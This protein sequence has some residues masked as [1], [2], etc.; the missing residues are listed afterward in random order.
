MNTV[1]R[2]AVAKRGLESRAQPRSLHEHGSTRH[3]ERQSSHMANETPQS[4][5][6]HR[7][8]PL[9]VLALVDYDNVKPQNEL[10]LDDVLDNANAILDALVG[11]IKERHDTA[12]VTV[13]LYG[14]WINELGQFT[15]LADWLLRGMP[16]LDRRR[17]GIRVFPSLATSIRCQPA[18][19]LVGTLRPASRGR[20]QKNG[21][22]QKMVDTML[23]MDVAH[24]DSEAP[25]DLLVA[26]DDDDLVPALLSASPRVG[27]LSVLRFRS[28]GIGLNDNHCSSLGVRFLRLPWEHR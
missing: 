13:R 11:A 18:T 8:T 12:D 5:G 7:E 14:G 20:A 21:K 26:S 9:Q 2:L 4:V 28:P 22:T 27:S 16:Q 3:R 6:D 24:H 10:A 1:S 15:P 19:T 23:A 25:R 17:K